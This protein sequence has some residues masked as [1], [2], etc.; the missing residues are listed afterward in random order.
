[1]TSG[2]E[3]GALSVL[4]IVTSLR[5][6]LSHF[7]LRNL[8]RLPDGGVELVAAVSQRSDIT[9]GVG[10]PQSRTVPGGRP[11]ELHAAATG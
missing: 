5:L 10:P 11:A 2:G 7:H 6:L 8:P 9:D 3:V 4:S 1:M